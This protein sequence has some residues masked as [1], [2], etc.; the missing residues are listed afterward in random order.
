[1]L[2][3]VQFNVQLFFLGST[4]PVLF[5]KRTQNPTIAAPVDQLPLACQDVLVVSLFAGFTDP[6]FLIGFV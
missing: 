1:V 3:L 4:S 6:D 5:T 2:I